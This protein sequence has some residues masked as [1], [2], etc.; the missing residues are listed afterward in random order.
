MSWLQLAAKRVLVTGAG[1]GIGKATAAAFAKAG[2][3]VTVL[4][5]DADAVRL[6]VENIRA[7]GGGDA[8]AGMTL[9]VSDAAAVR[10]AWGQLGATDCLVN[11]AG[12]TRDAWLVRMD[13]DSWDQ[14]VDVNLK[15]T[16]LTSQAFARQWMAAVEADPQLRAGHGA[17]IINVSSI[18]G[19][20][21]NLG[22]AN[23]A[24]SKGGVIALTK[25]CAKELAPF[26]VRV[27]CVLPGF[28]DTPM[29][30]AVPEKVLQK[31]I[32]TIPASRMGS[33]DEV[34]DTILFLASSRASFIT[35][36]PVEVTGGQGM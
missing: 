15:G 18:V 27:N 7:G 25:T 11:V 23:Y 28:I 24:A 35:G 17:S 3:S 21:G 12:I 1:S 19:K 32:P 8:V 29:A 2:S 16:F 30:A 26:N 14:V 34:A 22:Q 31:V 13:E 6:A 20:Q 4:D 33:P 9:D 5:R 36:Q 10:D